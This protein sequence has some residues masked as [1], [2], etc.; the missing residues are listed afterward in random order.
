MMVMITSLLIAVISAFLFVNL[1]NVKEEDKKQYNRK[2]W[3]L[4]AMAVYVVIDAVGAFIMSKKDMGIVPSASM[5]VLINA[6]FL[7]AVIDYRHK[8]IPNRYILFL[9]LTRLVFIVVQ[10]L[11]EGGVAD[12]GEVMISSFIG[13]VVGFVI[14]GITAFVTGKNL[15]FGDVKMYAVIGFF[16]GG[17]AVLDVLIYSTVI[18]AVVGIS[19]VVMKK[20]NM[21]TLVPMAPFAF[22]GTV[23]YVFLGM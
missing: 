2:K 10:G 19:L 5:C 13:F 12:V 22:F 7:L 4:V 14:L 1:K 17:A 16:T 11:C 21:K 3:F 6:L 23:L 20:C 15:G 9:L 8:I 18:C